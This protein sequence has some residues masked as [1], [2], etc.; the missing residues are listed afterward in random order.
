MK[1]F[2]AANLS[3]VE[4]VKA[5]GCSGANCPKYKFKNVQLV[6]ASK[7]AERAELLLFAII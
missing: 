4:I 7:L 1:A 2:V 6:S 3:E 5:R